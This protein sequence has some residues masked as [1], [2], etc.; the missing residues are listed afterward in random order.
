MAQYQITVDGSTVQ[1]LLTKDDELARLVEQVVNQV[2]EAQLAE[3]LRAAPYERTEERQGY[4]NGHRDR[5]MTMRV[6]RLVFEVPRARSG[7][8]STDLFER[9]QRSEQAL[10]LAMMRW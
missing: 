8:F 5:A 10:V 1:G 7:P 6:G 4:R 3:Q 9:Y 2:L